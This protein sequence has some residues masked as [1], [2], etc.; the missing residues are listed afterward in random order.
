MTKAVRFYWGTGETTLPLDAIPEAD[1]NPLRV[2]RS[3]VEAHAPAV[4]GQMEAGR[5]VAAVW[6]SGGELWMIL[7]HP[8]LAK[9]GADTVLVNPNSL[10]RLVVKLGTWEE[11]P[12]F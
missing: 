1:R 12:T 9:G 3:V 10:P 4:I 7:C 5:F 11:A 2:R 8:N 6:S